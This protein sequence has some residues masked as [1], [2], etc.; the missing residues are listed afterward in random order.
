MRA[1]N[2]QGPSTGRLVL[3][4]ALLT[5]SLTLLRLTSDLLRWS[6]IGPYEIAWLAPVFGAYFALSLSKDGVAAPGS[7]RLLRRTLLPLGIFAAGLVFFHPTSGGMGVASLAAILLVSRTWRRL[8]TVL[9]AYA[10]AARVP[11]ALIQLAA[12]W[13]GWDTVFDVS[14]YSAL[15]GL[16][17]QMT[18]W[19]GFTVVSGTSSGAAA[20]ALR[21]WLSDETAQATG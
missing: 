2:S 18:V 7:R 6:A 17:P 10:L 3:V 8:G 21:A 16:L 13:G 19:L 1:P 11:V 4:P 20:M 15:A 5:L 14:P 9:L 12:T